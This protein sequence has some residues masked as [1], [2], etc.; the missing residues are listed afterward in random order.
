[1]QGDLTVWARA[2]NY[3]AMKPL[4][5]LMQ[6]IFEDIDSFILL[7]DWPLAGDE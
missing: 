2:A 5:H 3:V 6:T 7:G 4:A 1:M